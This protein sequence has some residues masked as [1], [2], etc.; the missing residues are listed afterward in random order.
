MSLTGRE[1]EIKTLVL[2]GLKS[3]QVAMRLGIEEKTVKFHLTNIYAKMGVT[4]RSELAALELNK[5]EVSGKE[6]R[7]FAKLIFN[8]K[9]G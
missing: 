1:Q 4:T 5:S 9:E 8:E 6:V 3:A 7:E 2:Q